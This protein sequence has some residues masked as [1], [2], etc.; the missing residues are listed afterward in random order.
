V[1]TIKIS[2]LACAAQTAFEKSC[3]SQQGFDSDHAPIEKWDGISK[4]HKMAWVA[5][6]K[7]IIQ[8]VRP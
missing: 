7:E 6:V 2:E 4:F 1:R 3:W 8:H 5:A